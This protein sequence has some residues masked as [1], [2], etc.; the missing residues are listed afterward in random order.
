M[1]A[2]IRTSKKARKIA[3]AILGTSPARQ[4]KNYNADSSLSVKPDS[5][6]QPIMTP[7]L[8]GK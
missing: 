4:S 8:N 3:F 5:E 7:Q 1:P 2:M 6:S